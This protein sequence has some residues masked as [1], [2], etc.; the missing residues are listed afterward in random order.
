MGDDVAR[1]YVVVFFEHGGEVFDEFFDPVYEVR[2]DVGHHAADDVVVL[3]EASPGGFF[4]D[5]EHFFPVAEAVE[6]GGQRSHVHAEAG[7]EEEVGGEAVELVHDGADVFD[8]FRYFQSHGFFDA[9][10]EGVAVLVGG[11]VVQSVGQG[12]RLR[13]GEAFA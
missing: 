11:K 7:P 4:H 2:V 8:A 13:V 12:E 3:D 9:H 6:E 5:V 10:A 1:E